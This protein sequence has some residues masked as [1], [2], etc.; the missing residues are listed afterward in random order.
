MD[1]IWQGKIRTRNKTVKSLKKNR[2]LK[3][4]ISHKAIMK[5]II[6]PDKKWHTKW[7]Q[8]EI[9]VIVN[10][11]HLTYETLA[12]MVGRTENAVKVKKSRLKKRTVQT[13]ADD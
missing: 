3:W 1:W 13:N 10:N 6:K 7:K 12:K 4:K 11:M 8:S 5:P 9:C 2:N